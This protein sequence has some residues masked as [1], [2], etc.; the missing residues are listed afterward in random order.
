MYLSEANCP[1]SP[2][3]KISK[4]SISTTEQYQKELKWIIDKLCTNPLS[5]YISIQN[6]SQSRDGESW[7]SSIIKSLLSTL[8]FDG[9]ENGKYWTPDADIVNY[10][11][12]NIP[13]Q[14]VWIRI[15]WSKLEILETLL[16]SINISETHK[17]RIKDISKTLKT[18]YQKSTP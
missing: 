1:V 14:K 18:I 11:R 17:R 9:S 2:K 6:L 10:L 13:Q 8:S 7:A 15:L 12:E 3:K 16:P 4:T 5:H